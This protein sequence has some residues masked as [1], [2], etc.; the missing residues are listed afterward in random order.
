MT[1]VAAAPRADNEAVGID[2]E[3]A[4]LMLTAE[5]RAAVEWGDGPLM[6]LAGAAPARRPSWS[7]ASATC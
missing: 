6:V 1:A 3:A 7:S 5:Q 2:V 4:G